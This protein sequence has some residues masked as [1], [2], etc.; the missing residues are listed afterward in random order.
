[1]MRVNEYRSGRATSSDFLQHFAVGHLREPVPAVFLRR[2][3]SQHSDAPEAINHAA[4]NVSLPVDLRGIEICIEKL[5]KLAQSIVQYG[6]F[7]RGNPRIRHHPIC[8]ELP[9]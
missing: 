7:L 3:H 6:L 2:G 1:M 9:L 4:R 5:P 8:H